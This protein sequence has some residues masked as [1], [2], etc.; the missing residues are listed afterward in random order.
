[1]KW[2]GACIQA[3]SIMYVIICQLHGKAVIIVLPKKGWGGGGGGRVDGDTL[4]VSLSKK[5]IHPRI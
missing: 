4:G 5:Q 2:D 3:T 1:M